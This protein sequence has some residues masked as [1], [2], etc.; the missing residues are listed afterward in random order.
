MSN[1]SEKE[2]INEDYFFNLHLDTHCLPY[3]MDILDKAHYVLEDEIN[4]NKLKEDTNDCDY[5]SRQID[6]TFLSEYEK[7]KHRFLKESSPENFK[8]FYQKKDYF[9]MKFHENC[10]PALLGILNRARQVFQ[11]ELINDE[12]NVGSCMG[13]GVSDRLISIIIRQMVQIKFQKLKNGM[14]VSSHNNS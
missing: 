1:N 12:K 11:N 14:G 3:L 13:K 2:E 9:D 10:A 8:E 6:V 4:S 7:Y 5:L